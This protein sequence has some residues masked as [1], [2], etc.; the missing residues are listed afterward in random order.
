MSPDGTAKTTTDSRV[1]GLFQVRRWLIQL[2]LS[3]AWLFAALAGISAWGRLPT[4]DRT[5]LIAGACCVVA[6]WILS[7]RVIG[8]WL[9]AAGPLSL[10]IAAALSSTPPAGPAWIALAVSV[11]HVTYALILLTPVRIA[12]V[13]IPLGCAVL[14]IVWSWRPGNVIPGALAIGGGWIAVASL[15][16]SGAALWFVWQALLRQARSDDDRFTQLADRIQLEIASQE[17]SRLWRSAAVSVHERLLSTLRYILQTETLDRPGL[18]QL[19]SPGGD[20]T[21][22]PSSVDLADEVREATAA[23]IAAHIVRI[24]PS[25]LD[26]PVS[27]ETRLAARAAIVECALN[28]VLHGNATDVRVAATRRHGRCLITVSDNGTGIDPQAIPGIGWSATLGEGLAAIDGSWSTSRSADRTVITLD[29]PCLPEAS[30]PAFAEDGFQQG[31]ILMSAPLIAVGV[32]GASFDV[33]VAT[34]SRLGW[35]L[36]VTVVFAIAGAV[37]LVARARLAGLIASTAVLAGLAAIPWLMAAAGP[38]PDLAPV[39]AA[40]MT[41]AGYALIAVGMWARW[42]QWLVGMLAWA[43]GV[44]LVARVDGGDD[45]LPIAVALINCLIIVPVVIIVSAIGTRRY[46]RTQEA[47][48]LEREAMNREVIRAN[49]AMAINQ[50]LSACVAQAEDII[51]RLAQGAELDAPSRHQVA[52]LEGLIRATI[53]VD[54]ATSGEFAQVAARLVN[55]AFSQSIP[56]RVG[57]LLSSANPEPLDPEVMLALETAIRSQEAFTLR[58]LTDGVEDHLSLELSDT[59]PTARAAL[60]R[61]RL[62]A[63]SHVDIHVT[64]EPGGQSIVMVSRPISVPAA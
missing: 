61:L 42:W 39:L 47:T 10:V 48:A 3:E 14:A 8:L 13:A 15:A 27:D 49:S 26:L 24:D 6:G 28:A 32:V 43:A 60:D 33:I 29:V 36:L 59:D 2:L 18:A 53:Q 7:R 46:R 20:Q 40:G 38:P 64:Q 35:P 22:R 9:I 11:G 19:V 58:T 41:A 25:A 30:Q 34:S 37:I 23:R 51:D 54:P 52:C 12:P 17:R 55:S 16:V 44:L 62:L 5:L 4:A 45:Q 63:G 50:H 31:R 21:S 57:T 56:V 1:A